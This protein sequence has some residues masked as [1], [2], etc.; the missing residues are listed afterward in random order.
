MTCQFIIIQLF[1]NEFSFIRR[2]RISVKQSGNVVRQ[3]RVYSFFHQKVFMFLVKFYCGGVIV[4]ILNV[5]MIWNVMVHRTVP[6]FRNVVA[7]LRVFFIAGSAIDSLFYH[8][9][10]EIIVAKLTLLY[11]S[12]GRKC[13]NNSGERHKHIM[14]IS[15][16]I[17]GLAFICNL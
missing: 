15:C 10:S 11:R 9:P 16:V 5:W 7:T 14:K 17:Y 1:L 2:N 12:C 4:F 13:G 6:W 3:T 8:S